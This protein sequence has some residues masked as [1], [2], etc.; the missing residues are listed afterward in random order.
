MTDNLPKIKRH[1]EIIEFT[2]NGKKQFQYDGPARWNNEA[3]C[4]V[5]LMYP[6]K[7]FSMEELAR[8]AF[9]LA[10]PT[11]QSKARRRISRLFHHLFK[12]HNRVLLKE[13]E[14]RLDDVRL[15]S[16][17]RKTP[18]KGRNIIT[19]IKIAEF[20]DKPQALAE[21]EALFSRN[22]I[23]RTELQQMQDALKLLSQPEG[24]SGEE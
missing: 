18:L 11:N 8:I 19:R 13:Y 20:E 23:S 4:Q 9:R 24:L 22:E 10:S 16:K 17:I 3:I 1:A 7:W 5:L 15:M 12:H 14:R 6:A 21:L 2:K